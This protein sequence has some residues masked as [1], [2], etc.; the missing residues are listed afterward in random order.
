MA[1]ELKVL[2][3]NRV[4]NNGGKN[5]NQQMKKRERERERERERFLERVKMKMYFHNIIKYKHQDCLYSIYMKMIPETNL[6]EHN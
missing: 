5:K 1:L 4:F 6:T 2:E 3:L